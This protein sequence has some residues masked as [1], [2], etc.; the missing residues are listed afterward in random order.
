MKFNMVTKNW[1]YMGGR[2]EADVKGEFPSSKNTEGATYYPGA[3]DSTCALWIDSTY[4]VWLFGGNTLR[5]LPTADVW[6]LM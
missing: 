6:L 4:G 5:Y 3:R 2:T 1:A